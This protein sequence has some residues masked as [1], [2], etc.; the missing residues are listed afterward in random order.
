VKYKI[1]IDRT[2]CI[3]CGS[4]YSIDPTHFESDDE[5]KSIVIGG[6]TDASGSSGVFDDEEIENAREAEDSCPVAV[7]TVTEQ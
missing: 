2:G 1:E 7:I 3:A 4:C 6:E 5:G